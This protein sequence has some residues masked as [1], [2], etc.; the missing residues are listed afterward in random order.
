MPVERK[1]PA[2]QIVLD[3]VHVPGRYGRVV[4]IDQC[5][6]CR[7]IYFDKGELYQM[8]PQMTGSLAIV[9]PSPTASLQESG[10]G[11]CPGC[12]TS[13]TRLQNCNFPQDLHA[14]Q[15]SNCSGFW[16]SESDLYEFHQFRQRRM[17]EVEKMRKNWKTEVSGVAAARAREDIQKEITD[18]ILY[19]AAGLLTPAWIGVGLAL[20]EKLAPHLKRFYSGNPPPASGDASGKKR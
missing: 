11:N 20:A 7:G 3:P 6:M 4:E 2:C 10:G 13:L 17:A 9:A 14:W 19:P 5:G 8:G 1:C 15:C 18:K 12:S 16:L